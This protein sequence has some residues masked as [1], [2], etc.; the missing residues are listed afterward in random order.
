MDNP[1]KPA[2][3]RGIIYLQMLFLACSCT[4]PLMSGTMIFL[5]LF[6]LKSLYFV[7]VSV[8]FFNLLPSQNSKVISSIFLFFKNF[9]NQFF[10]IF[11]FYFNFGFYNL[12][13]TNLYL[14]FTIYHSD[15]DYHF[16][17]RSG[18]LVENALY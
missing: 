10:I 16:A 12:S 2:A 18:A 14:R 9:F 11:K 4:L 6:F 7:C 13:G 15:F 17:F 5:T 3:C 1:S 8:V